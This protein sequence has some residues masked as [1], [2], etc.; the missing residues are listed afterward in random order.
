MQ[1]QRCSFENMPG[2]TVCVRCGAVLDAS[3]PV[4]V[5]PPR[6]GRSK[7]FR[8]I[9]YW[10]NRRLRYHVFDM[11]QAA[12]ERYDV[13][14]A[15]E[16]RDLV[17]A[18]VSVV[19][20]LGH[21][22][23]G[24]LG[25]IKILWPVWAGVLL[26]GLVLYGSRM[27]G[28]LIGAAMAVHAWILC[29][30][31]AF[32]K[33]I[34]QWY[35]RVLVVL[36]AFALLL[37]GVYAP[38]RYAVGRVVRTAY[39]PVAFAEEGIRARDLLLVWLRAYRDEAPRRGDLMLCNFR[40]RDR[41][42]GAGYVIGGGRSI[43]RL[44]GMPGDR[45]VIEGGE[46]AVFKGELPMGTFPVP[47]YL[48]SERMGIVVPNDRYYC[49]PPTL[50]RVGGGGGAIEAASREY[51]RSTGLVSCSDIEGRVFMVYNPISRRRFISRGPEPTET[52]PDREPIRQPGI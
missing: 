43:V 1:C 12:P 36:G 41:I 4:D 30:A 46:I 42:P 48:A 47:D 20:G 35:G 28:L 33:R 8:P 19:P 3:S 27:G 21:L 5:N 23:K 34:E 29:D 9:G 37:F 32:R 14:L 52:P 2:L 44:L 18:M 11:A 24:E 51:M 45:I 25:R 38:M 16:R 31:G 10:L 13:K 40:G 50:S 26:L 15:R 7:L 49:L 17:L 6:A 22:L 39:A